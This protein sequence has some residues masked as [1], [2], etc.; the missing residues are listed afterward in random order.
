MVSSTGTRRGWG[1]FISLIV[2]ALILTL[3]VAPLL[4]SGADHLDAPSLGHISVNPDDTL[5]VGKVRG[6]DDINDL[7]VFPAATAGRTVLALRSIRLFNLIGPATF[8]SGAEYT[9]N[10]DT[11]CAIGACDAAATTLYTV[12]FGQPG[13][14]WRPALRVSQGHGKAVASASRTRPRAPPSPG[15]E[16]GHSPACARIILLRFARL[17]RHRQGPGDQPAARWEPV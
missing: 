17:P 7:Y 9:F 2:T 4:T 16:S 3:G 12:T 10:I 11:T 14:R 1:I 6:P 15:T 5:D 13:Q 8:D